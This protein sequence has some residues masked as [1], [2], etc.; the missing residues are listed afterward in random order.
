MKI[1]IVYAHSNPKSFC[2]ALLEQFTK[3]LEDAG[4]TYEV[5]D[6]HAMRFD[7][8]IRARDW[9]DWID[10]SMPLDLLERANLKQQLLDA[11]GGPL[12][13]FLMKRWLRDKGPLDMVKF[14]RQHQPKDIVAHQEKVARAQGLAFIAPV[15][16][17]G[18]P[19]ILKGW[20]DRV[21]SLGFA[22]GLTPE[23]WRGDIKGRIPLLK[24]EKALIINTTLFNE[25]TYR[26]LGLREAM[27][28]LIDE[29]CFRYPGIQKV[30]HVYFYAV[31]GA[32]DTT[33]QGYLQRA[34]LLG[35]E[36]EQSERLQ[37]AASM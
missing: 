8:V 18:F 14:I 15:Y 11:S 7:P 13:R 30:E 26:S 37:E 3:G 17:V 21:F 2:H 5:I 29:W 24:H 12:Q 23:G 1:L 36:F 19:A 35:K 16:F 27:E 32:D 33:R 6:L 34:Y 25:E 20:I 9:P 10:E 22:F 28:R 4:H 31:Y